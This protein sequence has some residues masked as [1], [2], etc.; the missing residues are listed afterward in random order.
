MDLLFIVVVPPPVVVKLLLI[1][2]VPLPVVV[3][4]LLLLDEHPHMPGG[5][6]GAGGIL[7]RKVEGEMA[8]LFHPTV[9]QIFKNVTLHYKFF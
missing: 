3:E 5:E 7:G 1:V 8:R 6:G 2:V 4:L 9:T